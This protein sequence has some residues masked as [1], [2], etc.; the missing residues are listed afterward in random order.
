MSSYK[1]IIEQGITEGRN[2]P[3]RMRE[4]ES[5]FYNQSMRNASMFDYRRIRIRNDKFLMELVYSFG[6][7]P[8]GVYSS[9]FTF[10]NY[11][12]G[13]YNDPECIG[14]VDHAMLLVGF[15][16]DPVYGDY[17][18]VKNSYGSDW[19]ENGYIR[20]TRS[21]ANFCNITDYVVLPVY[22]DPNLMVC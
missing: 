5:C 22:Q 2:Y 18:L 19:G 9:L 16:T 3:F 13:V 20:M 14:T 11:H 15:G 21:I 1:Y 7:I 10:L 17:W 6:P 8:I 4:L 12:E